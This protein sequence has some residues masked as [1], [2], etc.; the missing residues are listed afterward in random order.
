MTRFRFALKKKITLLTLFLIKLNDLINDQK[1]V[2][3]GPIQ[4]CL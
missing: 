2:M 3:T 4:Q 1:V